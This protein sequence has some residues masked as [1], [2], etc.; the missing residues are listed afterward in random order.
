MQET[1]TALQSAQEEFT[2]KSWDNKISTVEIQIS[3]IDEE[4]RSVQ[5]ELTSTSAQSENRAKIDVLKSDLTKKS[6][7]QNLLISSHTEKFKIL[8]GVDLTSTTIDSQ[9]NVL[10]R[11]KTDDLEEAERELDG[12]TKEITQFEAKLTT[13]KEQL[14]D[15]RK[16]KNEAHAKVM[17]LCE[18]DINEFPDVVKRLEAEVETL[19]M[20]VIPKTANDEGI[21]KIYSMRVDFSQILSNKRIKS[22]FVVYASE[23]S[24]MTIFMTLQREYNFLNISA[25]IDSKTN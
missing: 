18:S 7:A 14:R 10:L 13:C 22:T 15:K 19:K 17:E 5:T 9:I 20:Y 16:E 3:A 25:N 4:L 21:Y 8:V 24:P 1:T 23:I 12:K 2:Q 11:R 6:Q